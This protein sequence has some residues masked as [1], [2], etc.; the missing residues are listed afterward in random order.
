MHAL[1]CEE[2]RMTTECYAHQERVVA[3]INDRTAKALLND[4]PRRQVASAHKDRH[5]TLGSR[6]PVDPVRPGGPIG[7][8]LTG[9]T[10]LTGW[11]THLHYIISWRNPYGS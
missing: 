9:L 1:V 6:G 5:V 7:N 4:N 10:G 3:V 2:Q 8:S 11:T